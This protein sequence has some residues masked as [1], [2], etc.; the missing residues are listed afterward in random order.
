MFSR[1]VGAGGLVQITRATA[2]LPAGDRTISVDAGGA[3]VGAG[4]RFVF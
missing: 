2:K 1:N 4:L 3:Q